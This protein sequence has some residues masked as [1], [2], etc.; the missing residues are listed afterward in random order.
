VTFTESPSQPNTRIPPFCRPST[1]ID[2][3][4]SLTGTLRTSHAR[5]R[6]L[7]HDPRSRHFSS[8]S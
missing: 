7:F 6:S 2:R 3:P 4:L 1:E 8:H 5:P